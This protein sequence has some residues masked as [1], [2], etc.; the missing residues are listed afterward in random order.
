M[1]QYDTVAADAT[2]EKTKAALEANG[3]TVTMT[4]SEIPQT[5]ALL[6]NTEYAPLL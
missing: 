1:A 3:F 6:T 2:I 5:P 4:M